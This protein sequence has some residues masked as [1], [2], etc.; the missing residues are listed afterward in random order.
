[1]NVNFTKYLSSNHCYKSM[2]ATFQH[3]FRIP[4]SLQPTIHSIEHTHFGLSKCH[5]RASMYPLHSRIVLMDYI[6][7]LTGYCFQNQYHVPRRS[8][9]LDFFQGDKLA[10]FTIPIFLLRQIGFPQD[11]SSLFQLNCAMWHPFAYV[12]TRETRTWRMPCPGTSPISSFW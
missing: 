6:H 5:L 10:V 7:G 3:K 9:I 11:F 8:N 2:V 4:T 12:T 1:M